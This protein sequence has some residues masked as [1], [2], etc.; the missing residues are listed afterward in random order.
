MSDTA[1][2]VT[3]HSEPDELDA[4]M[5]RSDIV[6]VLGRLRFVDGRSVVSLD[7]GVRDFLVRALQR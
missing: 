1:T 3:K 6:E 5:T 7:R 4:D 2:A